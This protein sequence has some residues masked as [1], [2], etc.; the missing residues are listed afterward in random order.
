[1]RKLY[2]LLILG[3]CI[4]NLNAQQFFISGYLKDSLTHFPI[5]GGTISNPSNKNKITTDANGFFRVKAAPNDVLYA[6]APS[7]HYD[8]LRYS[9]LFTDTITIYLSPA[10]A[11]L[12]GLTVRSQYSKYQLDSIERKATFEQMRGQALNAV[13]SNRSQGFG[14]TLN[15]DRFTKKK[16]RNKKKEEKLFQKTEEVAYVNYRFSSQL[17]AY[18]TGLKGDSLR[19]FIYHYT[20]AYEWLRQHPSNE[21]VIYYINEKLKA[22]RNNKE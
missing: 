1:M 7:Y 17:V 11:V 3:F 9:L 16:Y 20:P 22:D 5:R 18:Y 8:T 6:I 13:A 4:S 15:L 10:G 21:E 2:C 14:I 19:L 12:P